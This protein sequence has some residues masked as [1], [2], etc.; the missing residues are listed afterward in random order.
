MNVDP[1]TFDVRSRTSLRGFTLVELLVVIAIIGVLIALLLPAVQAA[2][3]AARRAQCVN[4]LRQ[5]ALAMQSH[6]DAKGALP[7]SGYTT[8]GSD[9]GNRQGWPPQLWPFIEQSAIAEQYD[10]DVSFYLAPNAY[11]PGHPGASERDN[12][13]AAIPISLYYCPSDRGPAFYDYDFHRIRGNYFV[14]WGPMVYQPPDPL[15]TFHAPFGFEDYRSRNRPLRSRFNDFT[16][17][18]GTTLVLSEERMHPRD[19]SVDGRG[20][21]LNDGGD[22][23]FMTLYTPNTTVPDAQWGWYCESTLEVPCTT[24]GGSGTRRQLYSSARS[25]HPGGV[26]AAFADGHVAFVSDSVASA[27]W[28]AIGTMDGQETTSEP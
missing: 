23:V 19:E 2:R 27:Y 7:A 11:P 8:T 26:N 28:Q 4:N 14:N 25:Y 20:D 21:M 9:S 6:H 1:P 22:N 3:E 15:P 17:G 12:A 24:A 10:F 13:P 5:W 16:D 18:T